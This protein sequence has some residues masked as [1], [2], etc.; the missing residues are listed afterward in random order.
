M[1]AC[2]KKSV[3]PHPHVPSHM[4]SPLPPSGTAVTDATRDFTVAV[5]AAGL[6]PGRRYWYRFA[7]GK[8]RSVAGCTKTAPAGHVDSCIFATVSCANWSWGHFHCYDL[9]TRADDLD[10]VVHCGVR[11]VGC[12][13]HHWGLHVSLPGIKTEALQRPFPPPLFFPPLHP[14]RT[15]CTGWLGAG[16]AAGGSRGFACQGWN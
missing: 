16:G 1:A 13:S 10:F 12:T 8:Q 14:R 11:W 9:L 3:S 4:P 7:A 2:N 15:T 6:A 5:D